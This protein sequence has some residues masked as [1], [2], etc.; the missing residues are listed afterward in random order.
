MHFYALL[1]ELNTLIRVL[2]YS[3]AVDVKISFD[4]DLKT[5]ERGRTKL[6]LSL[7]IYVSLSLLPYRVTFDVVKIET[8]LVVRVNPRKRVTFGQ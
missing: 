3:T 6:K 7:F 1:F 4:F 8:M 5:P 2:R